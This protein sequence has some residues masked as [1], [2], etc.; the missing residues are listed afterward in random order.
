MRRGKIHSK[1]RLELFQRFLRCIATHLLR[2]IQDHDWPVC[3]NHIDRLPAAEFIQFHANPAGVLAA[4][5]ECLD[6]D[7]HD[8]Q[9]RAGTE[10][11]NVRKILRVVDKEAGLLP[12]IFHEMVLH[13][14]KA[15]THALCVAG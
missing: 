9:V 10:I 14:F 3:L 15:L 1:E 13:G 4:G 11:I 8:R 5:V 7:D 12:I 2:F 6:I